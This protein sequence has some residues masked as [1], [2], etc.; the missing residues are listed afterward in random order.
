MNSSRGNRY[1]ANI[2]SRLRF[3]KFYWKIKKLKT[4]YLIGTTIL[5][6]HDRSMG[7]SCA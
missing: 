7:T 6:S 2:S 1:M 3:T 5:F 4:S